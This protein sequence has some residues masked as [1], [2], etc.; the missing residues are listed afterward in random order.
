MQN[1]SVHKASELPPGAKSAVEQVL[2]R[3]IAAEEEI[4]ISATPPKHVQ[5]S[6]SR[7]S[8]AAKLEAFLNRRASKVEGVSDV[9]LDTAI[10]EAV[11]DARHGRG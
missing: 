4:S 8:A 9:E 7:A 5:P 11:N 6:P 2:G 1:I 3:P 10:E